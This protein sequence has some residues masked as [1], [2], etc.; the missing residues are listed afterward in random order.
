[1][2]PTSITRPRSSAASLAIS[3]PLDEFYARMGLTLPPLEQVDGEAVPQPYRLVSEIFAARTRSEWR[4]FASEH[5]C[6]LEPV[7]DLDESLSSELVA[8]REMVVSLAQPGVADGVKLLGLPIKLTRTPGDPARA[9]A[10]AL[11]EHTDEVLMAAG[12]SAEEI[13][14]LRESG[15]VAGPASTTQGTF[16]RA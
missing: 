5:D 9:P 3:H 11:G 12:F 16:L 14:A 15:A 13:A 2:T 10:P 8:G 6:C 4:A 1:M 7:L